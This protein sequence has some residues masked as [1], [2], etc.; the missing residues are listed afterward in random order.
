MTIPDMQSHIDN[1]ARQHNVVIKHGTDPERSHSHPDLRMICG[2]LVQSER[3][4]AILLHEMGHIVAPG[5]AGYLP[6][7][8][9]VGYA[10]MD[11]D[12]SKQDEQIVRENLAWDWARQQAAIWTPE[13]EST[14]QWGLNTYHEK[15]SRLIRDM[16]SPMAPIYRST[17]REAWEQAKAKYE[18]LLKAA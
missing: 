8:M 11:R 13:M 9:I 17:M 6:K 7:Q 4:Y 14:K 18:L 16:D 15:R 3:D 10:L 1:L 5:A 2:M 12:I